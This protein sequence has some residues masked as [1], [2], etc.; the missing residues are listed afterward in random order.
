MKKWSQKAINKIVFTIDFL[1]VFS[2]K[3]YIYAFNAYYGPILGGTF[4]FFIQYFI[5]FSIENFIIGYNQFYS[6]GEK[7]LKFNIEFQ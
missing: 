4:H 1:I 7:V 5:K 2:R 3:G 6:H